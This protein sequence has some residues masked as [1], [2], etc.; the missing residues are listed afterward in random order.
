MAERDITKLALCFFQCFVTR[1]LLITAL[2]YLA[3]F[4][5]FNGSLIYIKHILLISNNL[6][7]I[8]F[9]K[10]IPIT[11]SQ[12]CTLYSIGNHVLTV[13]KNR[14]NN[15]TVGIGL[16]EQS[17][18]S[19]VIMS[20]IVSQITGVSIVCSAVCSGADQRKY[21]S[22]ALLAFVRGIHWWPVDSSQRASKV[23]N[24]SIWWRLDARNLDNLQ[25]WIQD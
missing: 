2:R 13:M 12:G 21:Q 18:C 1:T 11:F 3:L 19:D 14:E 7:Q 4:N 24:V 15:G 22:S 20:E 23:E 5:V 6:D 10:K 9:W 25:F 16:V 17:H 8:W